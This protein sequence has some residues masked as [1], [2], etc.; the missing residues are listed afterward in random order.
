[1]HPSERRLVPI[2]SGA[3][4][5]ASARPLLASMVLPSLMET[6]KPVF[7]E[8]NPKAEDRAFA[9]AQSIAQVFDEARVARNA[10]KLRAKSIIME[11][12]RAAP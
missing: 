11:A 9:T 12:I 5:P 3:L 7:D 8:S 2:A 10:A 6:L 4:S 1:M